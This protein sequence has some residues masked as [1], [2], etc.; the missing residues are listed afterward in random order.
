MKPG[1]PQRQRLPAENPAPPRPNRWKV[2]V[3]VF[4]I[5]SLLVLVLVLVPSRIP[6]LRPTSVPALPAI[7]LTGAAPAVQRTVAAHVADVQQHPASATA[8]GQLGAVLFAYRLFAPAVQVL[9]QAR[10]LDPTNPRWPH[11]QAL[12][13]GADSPSNALELLRLASRLSRDEPPA[14]RLRLVR[15]LAEQARWPEVDAELAPLLARSP[16]I[17]QALL[18]AAQ[19]ALNR[20]E[21][22][23]ARR[24]A[25]RAATH[26]AVARPA[27][28]LL[29]SLHA[30]QGRSEEAAETVRRA[31]TAPGSDSFP[32]PHEAEAL[33]LREDP[34]AFNEQV[35]PLLARG[36]LAEAGLVVDRMTRDHAD[37]PDT[38]LAA[39]RL[40]YLRKDAPLAERHLRHHLQLEARSVQGW[41]QLG[42]ALLQQKKDLD[43]AEAFG[44]A[45]ALKPDLSPAWHNRGLALGRQGRRDEAM[46]AF[47]QVLRHSPE[48]VDAYVLFADL[49]LQAGNPSAALDLIAQAELLRPDDPRLALLRRKANR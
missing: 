22:D 35:H 5:A 43:A 32:D 7:D 44:R 18:L 38:W 1:H 27:L 21:S 37:F 11:L 9:D 49:Q 48:H 8:R 10:T 4:G 41:F 3:A 14:S 13:L 6:G 2:G 33:A 46:D 26:P 45:V 39:G 40:A 23:T 25:E 19:T 29:A 34:V 28:H 30:R 16:E 47:R 20:G 17:P 36:R 24:L 31:A 15:L 12:V 42:M